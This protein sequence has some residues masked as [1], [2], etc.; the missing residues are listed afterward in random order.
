[1]GWS[2]TEDLLCV[3]DDG[4]VLVYD[5]HGAIKKTLT[6]GQVGNMKM[7]FVSTTVVYIFSIQST[8]VLHVPLMTTLNNFFE[9][10]GLLF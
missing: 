4:T 2:V 5:I 10:M 7:I 1:M 6:M 8:I 3:A 9:S